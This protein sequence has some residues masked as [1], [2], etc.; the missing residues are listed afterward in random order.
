MSE[1]NFSTPSTGGMFK[2][3][4]SGCDCK[5]DKIHNCYGMAEYFLRVMA[6][7]DKE[8]TFHH[9]FDGGVMKVNTHSNKRYNP[10]EDIPLSPELSCFVNSCESYNNNQPRIPTLKK[11]TVSDEKY[12]EAIAA[13]FQR[14]GCLIPIPEEY[15]TLSLKEVRAVLDRLYVLSNLITSINE[16]KRNYTKIFYYT[17]FLALRKQSVMNC[18][19]DD[20]KII[21]SVSSANN[22]YAQN[23]IEIKI[24]EEKVPPVSATELVFYPNA[25]IYGDVIATS[26]E[27]DEPYMSSEENYLYYPVTDYFINDGN[28]YVFLQKK[29][30]LGDESGYDWSEAHAN[31]RINYLYVHSNAENRGDKLLIDFLY[32][33]H[34]EVMQISDLFNLNYEIIKLKENIN[35]NECEAFN[36]NYKN[37]LIEIA[38]STIKNEFDAAVSKIHPVYN[39]EEMIPGWYI[40][41]LYTAI[42]YGEFLNNS[43]HKIYRTCANPTCNKLFYTDSTNSRRRYCNDACRSAAAQ[44]LYRRRHNEC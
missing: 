14:Y 16:T 41:D 19:N 22:Y 20:G 4:N 3:K 27:T 15:V 36:D 9:Y 42:Y 32:H 39:S 33:F 29:L 7:G 35:L 28:D 13:F 10:I 26:D 34:N 38:R 44:R 21:Y 1:Y 6:I 24:D 17:M 12:A 8:I 11:D 37:I 23:C 40:P 25:V 43:A 31:R 5:V 30:Y 2:F 18:T